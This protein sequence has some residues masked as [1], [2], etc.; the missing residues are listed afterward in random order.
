M[1][2]PAWPSPL[3]LALQTSPVCCCALAMDGGQVVCS[4][5][6]RKSPPEKK[7]RFFVSAGRGLRGPQ[8]GVQQR[9]GGSTGGPWLAVKGHGG[10]SL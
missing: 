7:L 5:W 1:R 8:L 2:T 3:L 6:L 4:G 10:S 9:L